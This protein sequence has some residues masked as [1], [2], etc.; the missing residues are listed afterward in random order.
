MIPK[1]NNETD[2][3]LPHLFKRPDILNKKSKNYSCFLKEPQVNDGQL[4]KM[5]RKSN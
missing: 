5:L 3:F 4:I 1:E 2:V